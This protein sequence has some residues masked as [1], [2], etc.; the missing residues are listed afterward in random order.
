M[1]MKVQQATSEPRADRLSVAHE[2]LLRNWLQSFP[3]RWAVTELPE[4]GASR[5][6]FQA[7][8]FKEMNYELELLK[9]L[10]GYEAV[11]FGIGCE[12]FPD[13]IDGWEGNDY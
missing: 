6:V 11:Y 4:P 10:F 9:E 1:K 2:K 7:A 8:I 3:P 12:S 5:E 13:A